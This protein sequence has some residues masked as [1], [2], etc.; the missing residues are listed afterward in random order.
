MRIV[1]LEVVFI[2][3]LYGKLKSI[4]FYLSTY[5][6]LLGLLIKILFLFAT[7]ILP[8][9]PN[10]LPMVSYFNKQYKEGYIGLI[11]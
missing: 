1:S 3:N 9:M 5:K 11:L 7:K 8:T 10:A 4:R 2:K 6:F